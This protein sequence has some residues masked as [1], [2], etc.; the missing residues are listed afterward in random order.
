MTED[1]QTEQTSK[2]ITVPVP[3]RNE[4]FGNREKAAAPA[5]VEQDPAPPRRD[6][7][8]EQ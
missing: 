2:G 3:K 5:P 6:K 8:A 7:L 4:F 1:P